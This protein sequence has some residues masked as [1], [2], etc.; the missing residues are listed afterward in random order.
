[1]PK[2]VLITPLSSKI[3]LKDTNS[4]IDGLIQLD[5]SDNL[6]ITSPNGTLNLGNAASN[7]VIG[8]GTNS[9]DVIFEQNGS[10]R[11]LTGK[12][13]TLGQ[14]DSF[15]NFA[16]RTTAFKGGTAEIK[17]RTLDDGT[18]SFEGSAGQLFSITDSMS[19]TIFSV[20]DISGI[21]SIEV[22]DT[23]NVRLAQ[24]GG[25][26]GIGTSTPASKFHVLYA[27]NGAISGP[28]SGTWAA[29]IVQQQDSTAHNGLSIQNRWA[30]TDSV[31]FEAAFGWNGSTQGYFPA[32][33][34]DG[35]GQVIVR[36]LSGGL[37]ERFRI[38]NS[39]NVGIGTSAPTGRLHVFGGDFYVQNAGPGDSTAMRVTQTSGVTYIQASSSTAVG[40]GDLHL[41][42]YFTT[43]Y[44][45]I[46]ANGSVGINTTNPSTEFR[47]DVNGGA[48]SLAVLNS[49]VTTS[50]SLALTDNGKIIEV[51][52]AAQVS[53]TI[54]TDASVA[55][56]V[57]TQIMLVQYGVGQISLAPASG[58]TVRSKGG[59]LRTDTQ[60]S[61]VSLYKR[62]ANDWVATG[63][64]IV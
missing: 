35:L 48:R 51:N 41:G 54:P 34:I 27:G 30:G 36:T 24:Y 14:S 16:S 19:G 45:V 63:D 28:T 53:I 1:M 9:V 62:A 4:N 61:A 2:D 8:D 31:I 57:G 6:S 60:Y 32:F 47:L 11:G 37:P 3:E 18:L 5:A 17:L 64:L 50:Y 56:P 21:P 44:V 40:A 52:A 7:V 20:N 33:T 46:K 42:N 58:V 49:S 13:V 15:V 59:R 22:L 25:N 10:I 55:F 38:N 26:V 23:G 43:G 29:R 12:T 39:G